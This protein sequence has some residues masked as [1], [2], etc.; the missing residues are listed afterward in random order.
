MMLLTLLVPG[1]Y[2]VFLVGNSG[3]VL[4]PDKCCFCPLVFLPCQCRHASHN[5]AFSVDKFALVLPIRK[6]QPSTTF[7]YPTIIPP[8]V[9]GYPPTALITLQMLCN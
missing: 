2:A 3:T 8:T 1:H 9:V 6:R 5:R 4:P 7:G